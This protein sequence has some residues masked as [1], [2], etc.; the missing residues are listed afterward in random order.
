[1][2]RS[3]A[4]AR[5][6]TAVA[7][8]LVLAGSVPIWTGGLYA[9]Y[10]TSG[11]VPVY[12]QRALESLQRSSDGE[13]AWFVPG[14]LQAFYRWGGLGGGVPEL[15]PDLSAVRRPGVVVA[16]RYA[17]DLLAAME[18]PFQ[19]GP[20]DPGS[21]APLMRYLGTRF[22]VLQNDLDWERSQTARPFELQTL[23]QQ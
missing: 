6:A 5:G 16:G 8:V 7:A 1:F 19:Q 10:R 4:L 3:P 15:Y 23:V 12:W 2:R 14:S 9:G 11:P 21:T 17:N 13:R 22:A 20:N 18:Q